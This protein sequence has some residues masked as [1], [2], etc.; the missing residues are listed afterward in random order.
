MVSCILGVLGGST[1]ALPVVT[2]LSDARPVQSLDAAYQR[3]SAAY[4]ELDSSAAITVYTP[5]ALYLQPDEQLVQGR[6]GIQEAFE[7]LF[8]WAEAKDL[9][10]R[11][12][13]EIMERDVERDLAYDVGLY[14]LARLREGDELG[15]IRGKFVLISRRQEDGSW[16]FHVDGFS[17]SPK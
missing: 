7:R 12:T 3:L 16:L 14:T 4:Q 15:S 6:A 2:H 13:F 17:R 10:L 1:F 8:D 11:L 5:D 9:E